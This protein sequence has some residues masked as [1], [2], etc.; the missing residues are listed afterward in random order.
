MSTKTPEELGE[1][2]NLPIAELSDR[3]LDLDADDLKALRALEDKSIK[4]KGAYEAID[5]ASELL[6]DKAAADKAA[7]DKAA[8]DKAAA[9][10]AA[11]DK[12]AADKA[13]ANPVV[14]DANA[15]AHDGAAKSA[16]VEAEAVA[17]WQLPDYTGPLDI[18]KAE[19]RRV[20][21]KPVDGFAT[22]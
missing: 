2:Q 20:N 4:R 18:E 15:I 5:A 14:S 21:L 1:I 17:N 3:L 7:A 12:A 8:A 11:A 10:K 16:P 22:K 13:A 19:W 6:T 9:D